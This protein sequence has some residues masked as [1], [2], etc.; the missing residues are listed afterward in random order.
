MSSETYAPSNNMSSGGTDHHT[1]ISD[2]GLKM[3]IKR[4]G[5]GSGKEKSRKVGGVGAANKTTAA[6]AQNGA[7]TTTKKDKSTG[8]VNKNRNSKK[9]DKKS[10]K[11]VKNMEPVPN[12]GA[13][14]EMDCDDSSSEVNTWPPQTF[15]NGSNVESPTTSEP[16]RA[17]SSGSEPLKRA[18][19]IDG[20]KRS[21]EGPLYCSTE[22]SAANGTP[23]A[24]QHDPYDFNAKTE[25]TP[26]AAYHA[27]KP[28]TV[29][30]TSKV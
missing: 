9:S 18:A 27:K 6:T 30:T 13:D 26:P 3:K 24:V 21:A 1:A 29:N 7:T 4:K 12:T 14:S 10:N 15:N 20:L 23:P 5:A 11:N 16:W 2:R 19:N 17:V 22:R 28:K 8:N 25:E